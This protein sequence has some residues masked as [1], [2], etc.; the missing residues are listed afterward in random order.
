MYPNNEPPQGGQPQQ[1]WGSPEQQPQGASDPYG[2]PPQQPYGTSD[3]YGSQP[4]QPYGAMPAYPQPGYPQPGYPMGPPQSANTNGFAIASF[5]LSL[6]GCGALLAVPFGVIALNQIK[7]KGE[8]GK[9]FAIAGLIISTLWVLFVVAAVVISA[10]SPDKPGETVSVGDVSVGDCIGDVKESGMVYRTKTVPCDQPHDAEVFYQFNVSGSW[11]GEDKVIEEAD[12]T[13]SAKLDAMFA[14]SPRL[15]DLSTFMLYPP[16]E[17]NFKRSSQ[18]TC[19]VVNLD[20]SKLTG[21]VP[22]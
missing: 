17:R 5:V 21:K 8:R 4:P 6:I 15:S 11:P 16:D 14:T 3:P 19:M 18:I 22:R 10:V 1:P 2:A 13:C 7:A 12:R 20:G 9:G